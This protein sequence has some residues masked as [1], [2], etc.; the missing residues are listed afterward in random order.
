VGADIGQLPT[1]EVGGTLARPLF[2][3]LAGL[4]HN[5][6]EAEQTA[7]QMLNTVNSVTLPL[8][9]GLAV[10]SQDATAVILGPKWTEAAPFLAGFALI[11]T[12]QSF[13]N[14]LTTLLNV[15]GYVK[16]Q[17]YAIWLEFVCFAVLSFFLIPDYNLMGLVY[18]RIA[19]GLIKCQIVVIATSWRSG[20]KILTIYTA[21]LPAIISAVAMGM[22]LIYLPITVQH[23][24]ARLLL[25]I[26][27]GA[28]VYIT[29][30]LILWNATGRPSGAI[31]YILSRVNKIF[32]RLISQRKS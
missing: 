28:A 12:I 21:V 32:K 2:P 10:V 16:V 15:A 11:G 29:L 6:Q 27:V 26:A 30:M 7:L 17:T 18:A 5:W 24:F 1:S 4:K 23:D 22:V 25:K 3:I 19:A 14:P 8:G 20:L 31:N 9:I 13:H